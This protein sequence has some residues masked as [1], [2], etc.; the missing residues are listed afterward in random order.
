ML[1]VDGLRLDRGCQVQQAP[2]LVRSICGVLLAVAALALQPL[3]QVAHLIVA[4]ERSLTHRRLAEGFAHQHAE[5][6]MEAETLH[7]AYSKLQGKLIETKAR[8]E[9]LLSQH[10]RNKSLS[11][12]NSVQ[13]ALVAASLSRMVSSVEASKLAAQTDRTINNIVGND[14]VEAISKP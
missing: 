4:L 9:L 7:T 10:R 5:Q 3:Q 11:K 14:T 2:L 12:R 1:P 13:P 6:M 8:I